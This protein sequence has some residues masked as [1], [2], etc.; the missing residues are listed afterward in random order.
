MSSTLSGTYK[1]VFIPADEEAPMEQR[2]GDKS[3]GL[4]KDSLVQTAKD[5]FFHQSGGA[6]R[7]EALKRAPPQEQQAIAQ[8]MRAQILAENPN[9]ASQ[10]SQMKDEALLEL[11]RYVCTLA[12]DVLIVDDYVAI[13]FC[14]HHF[15]VLHKHPPLV[16]SWQSRFQQGEIT[17]TR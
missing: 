7:A 14:S 4:Q 10:L 2:E 1:Y 15:L 11:V 17:F 16:K 8:K 5:F 3:G 12:T 13:F 6:A 9:A